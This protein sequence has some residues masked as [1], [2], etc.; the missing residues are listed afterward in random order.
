MIGLSPKSL[1]YSRQFFIPPARVPLVLF[2]QSVFKGIQDHAICSFGLVIGSRVGDRDV[3]DGDDQSSQ[4]SQKSFLVKVDPKSVMIL[5]G[6][7][8]WCIM[9]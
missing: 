9:S 6:R 7:P 4:K 2:I 1:D 8:K 3:L 5:F